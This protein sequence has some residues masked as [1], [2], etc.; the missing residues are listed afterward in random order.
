MVWKIGD[1]SSCKTYFV[2]SATLASSHLPVLLY[3][4]TYI[5]KDCSLVHVSDVVVVSE[6]QIL[7]DDHMDVDA[8]R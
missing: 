3:V 5:Q 1:V 6:K 4:S 2:S 8:G 7:V